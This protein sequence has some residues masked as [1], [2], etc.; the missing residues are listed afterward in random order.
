MSGLHDRTVSSF[1]ISIGTA[2]AL[3]SLFDARQAPYDAERVPLRIKLTEHDELWVNI[4]TLL[5]NLFGAIDKKTFQRATAEE[6][7]ETLDQELSLIASLLKEEGHNT[8]QLVPYHCHYHSLYHQK[9]PYGVKL[10]QDVTENQRDTAMKTANAIQCYLS[11][12]PDQCQV[13]PDAVIGKSSRALILTHIPFDLLSWHSFRH[14]ALL[15]SH[16]GLLKPRNLWYTKYFPVTG[17]PLNHLPLTRQLLKLFGDHVMFS[18]TEIALRRRLLD[19]AE[20]WHW[21][22]LTTEEKISVTVASDI[23]DADW[24]ALWQQL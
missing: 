1:P 7:A 21:T 23:K 17:R 22:P 12:Y 3:E 16:T 18:P 5:R 24:M 8:C 13:F 9:H 14:L 20:A 10:R 4:A 11:L 2:L 6:L 15:E 19:I